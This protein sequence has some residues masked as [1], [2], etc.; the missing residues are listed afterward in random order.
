MIRSPLTFVL[1][2]GGHNTGIISEPGHAGR[3][4][5]YHESSRGA[6]YTGPDQWYIDA[7]QRSGSWWLAWNSWLSQRSSAVQITAPVL[8][9]TLPEAPGTYVLQK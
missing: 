8:D 5:R 9:Q 4:Y 6:V 1:T 2:S 7:E 3:A